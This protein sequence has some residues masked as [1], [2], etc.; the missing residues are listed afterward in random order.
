MKKGIFLSC[1]FCV[2]APFFLFAEEQDKPKSPWDFSLTTDFAYYPKSAYK[3]GTA[4]KS[5]FAPL[6]GIY[7]GVEFRVTGTAG[8][9]IPVHFGSGPLFKD[10]AVRLYADLELSPVSFA[11]A[12]GVSFT[13]IA[14]LNFSAGTSIGAAWDFI[15]VQGLAAW[16]SAAYDSALKKYGAYKSLPFRSGHWDA[17]VQGAFMFDLAAVVPGDWNHV[18]TYNSYRVKYRGITSG[19]ENGNPWLYQGGGENVNGWQYGANF[20]IAYQMPLV[21]QAVALQTEL[22]GLFDGENDFHKK[23]RASEPN[24]MSASISPVLV[25]KFTE[26]DSLTTQFKFS[27]RRRFARSYT[28]AKERLIEDLGFT[29]R[30]WYFDRIALSYKHRF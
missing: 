22:S 28:A 8:Y 17:W 14:F 20:I 11:P 27:S 15:G 6:S 13:P 29:G 21:L 4:D 5:H 24:F 3:A 30:E 26:K 7:S 2:L 1:L 16:D 9:T 19:G 10:N 23:Y 18:V 25:F 12:L